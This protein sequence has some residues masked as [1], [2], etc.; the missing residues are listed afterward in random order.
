LGRDWQL[1]AAKVNF[2]IELKTE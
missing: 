2:K 1:S